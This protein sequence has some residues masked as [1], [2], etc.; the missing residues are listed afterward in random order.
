MPERL[1][2]TSISFSS[3]KITLSPPFFFGFLYF[4]TFVWKINIIV[5]SAY[6]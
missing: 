3:S 2:I 4:I 1:R 5:D 6:M